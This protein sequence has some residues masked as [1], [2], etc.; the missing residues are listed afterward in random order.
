MK[1]LITGITAL[2]FL[3]CESIPKQPEDIIEDFIVKIF[4]SDS[5]TIEDI[6]AFMIP[7]YFQKKNTLSEKNLDIHLSFMREITNRM[8]VFLKENNF[9]YKIIPKNSTESKNY[10][11]IVYSRNGS[12][13]LMT[14]NDEHVATFIIEDKKLYAYYVDIYLSDKKNYVPYFFFE[15]N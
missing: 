7:E 12:V 9:E 14:C 11:N 13:F 8:K 5:Y 15:K 1:L 2:L 10:K 6:E 3:S 4:K